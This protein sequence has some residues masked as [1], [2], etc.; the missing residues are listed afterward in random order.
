MLN[1]HTI[2]WIVFSLLTVKLLAVFSLHGGE[3]AENNY[4]V[5]MYVCFKRI[6]FGVSLR[7]CVC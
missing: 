4:C 7:Q 5:F 6:C 3:Y 1:K 2:H